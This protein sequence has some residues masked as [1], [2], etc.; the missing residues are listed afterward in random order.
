MQ[1][2]GNMQGQ[3]FEIVVKMA[4]AANYI[5]YNLPGASK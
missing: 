2:F 5:V 4:T 1:Y 3:T